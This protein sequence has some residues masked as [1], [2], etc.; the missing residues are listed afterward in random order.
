MSDGEGGKKHTR[1]RSSF[2][3]IYVYL[4]ALVSS[5]HKIKHPPS[6]N[7]LLPNKVLHKHPHPTTMQ[8]TMMSAINAAPALRSSITMPRATRATFRSGALRVVRMQVCACTTR[9][10]VSVLVPD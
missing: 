10:N 6:N 3:S 8:T 5:I 9:C 7:L 4:V 2:W 1:G